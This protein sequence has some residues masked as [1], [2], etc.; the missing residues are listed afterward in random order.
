MPACRAA[1]MI[2]ACFWVARLASA[3]RSVQAD[4]FRRGFGKRVASSAS[5]IRVVPV[6]TPLVDGSVTVSG[7][8]LFAALAAVRQVDLDRV[9]QQR[10]VIMTRSA[11]QHHSISGTMLIS[12]HRGAAPLG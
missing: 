7:F 8:A 6:Q 1:D 11:A 3:R 10:R 12:L 9:G 5:S 4:R 2:A